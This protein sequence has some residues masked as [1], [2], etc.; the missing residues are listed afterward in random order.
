MVDLIPSH[1]VFAGEGCGQMAG[2]GHHRA[3]GEVEGGGEEGGAGGGVED[4][5]Q[6][7]RQDPPRHLHGQ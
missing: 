4:H 7:P 1:I 3:G 2:P 5:L 6:D